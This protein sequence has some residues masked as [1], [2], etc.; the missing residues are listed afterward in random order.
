M[1]EAGVK[2]MRDYRNKQQ[3]VVFGETVQGQM[4]LAGRMALDPRYSA[5]EA[6]EAR[7]KAENLNIRFHLRRGLPAERAV[8]ENMENRRKAALAQ[9]DMDVGAYLEQGDI[10][11]ANA[12]M[13]RVLRDQAAIGGKE[14]RYGSSDEQTRK[15]AFNRPEGEGA[16]LIG[17]ADVRILQ[18]RIEKSAEKIKSNNAFNILKNIPMDEAVGLLTSTEGRKRFG[19]S[20]KQADNVAEMLSTRETCKRRAEKEAR[21]AA[22]AEVMTNA[23][24]LALGANGLPADPVTALQMIRDN[25]HIDGRTKL[26]STQALKKGT[27]N[28]DDPYFVTDIKERM[29]NGEPVSDTEVARGIATGKLSLATKDRISQ[30]REEMAGPRGGLIKYATNAIKEAFK[31]D[32]LISGTP[33]LAMNKYSAL[34]ELDLVIQEGTEKGDLMER[35]DPTSK[36][37]A[38]PGIIQRNK[39]SF[40]DRMKVVANRYSSSTDSEK[41]KAMDDYLEKQRGGRK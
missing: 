37:F 41:F 13:E 8:A 17:A 4:A 1:G 29:V 20:G 38:L 30:L 10:A 26:E 35:L 21:D 22:A 16:G 18:D 15:S 31:A 3:E 19:L 40:E 36:K 39:M 9:L 14:I 34:R 12:A 23:V 2:R 27:I 11:G 5:E 7:R 28:S 33:E 6:D 25:P 24:N 32:T